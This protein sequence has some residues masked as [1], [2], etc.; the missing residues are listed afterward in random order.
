MNSYFGFDPYFFG[1]KNNGFKIAYSASIGKADINKLNDVQRNKIKYLL[2]A[3]NFISVRDSNT[4]NFVREI[5]NLD[6]FIS[7]DPTLL[8]T[9]NILKNFINN[10]EKKL[11]KYVIIYGVVFPDSEKKKIL[12]YCKENNLQ[13]ISIGYNNSWV[14]KNFICATPTEFIKCLSQ[15]NTIFTSMF[16]GI[17]LSVKLRK[18]FWYSVDPIRKAKIAYF[19]DYLNLHSRLL[20]QSENLKK[21]FDYKNIENKLF[22][23]I[24]LS[25]EYLANSINKSGLIK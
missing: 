1:E 16:H 19:V 22:D 9:P 8:Y 2:N 21:E 12:N 11:N 25:R 15:A 23:W 18:K 17:I 14:D 3:F 10:S 7:V 5:T 4:A 20:S 13:S 6:P 24:K